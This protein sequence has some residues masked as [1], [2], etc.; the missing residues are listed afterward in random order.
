MEICRRHAQH[1]WRD[2]LGAG[3]ADP[4]RPSVDPDPSHLLRHI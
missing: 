1:P 3:F 4:A 2:R